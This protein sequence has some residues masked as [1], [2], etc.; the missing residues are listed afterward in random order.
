MGK[1]YELVAIGGSAGSFHVILQLVSQ[2]SEGFDLP[3]L[4]ITHRS[5][6]KDYQFINILNE[7]EE[8]ELILSGY[9]YVC[10]PDYHLLIEKDKTLSLDYS[11]KVNHSRPSIDVTFECV[12]DIYKEKAIAI[13][14]S[15]ANGDG[16]EGLHR[17]HKKGGVTIVQNPKNAEVPVMPQRALELFTADYIIEADEIGETFKKLNI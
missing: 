11:E 3:V 4:I 15:G 9:I 10:P 12:A 8:K 17:I 16:A 5:R 2:L 13:L 14:L 7:A 1:K 6:G